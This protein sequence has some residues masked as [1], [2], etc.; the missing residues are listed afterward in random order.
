MNR[1]HLLDHGYIEEIEHW[2]SDE[3]IVE[4]ARVS[5]NKGFLGWGG[6]C[7]DSPHDEDCRCKG[8]GK[9]VGDEKLLR[10]MREHKHTS[11]F[12]F[13]GLVIEIQA[14]IF[15]F[16]EWQRHRT[17]S[18]SEMSARYTPLPDFNYVPTVERLM[19]NAGTSN[20]QAGTVT[21][22][23]ELTADLAEAARHGIKD[24][25]WQIEN[26]YQSLLRN[27]VPKELARIIIPVGRYSRMRAQ[28][29]LKNWLDFLTLRMDAAAQ[30]EIRQYANAV[31][32]IIKE[33]FPRTWELFAEGREINNREKA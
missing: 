4:T 14:P 30:W 28:A 5:T 18:Y 23:G 6:P 17:Q 24:L 12:E 15:V 31:G 21:G 1:V 11:P 7:P 33:R 13:A 22:S 29:V 10:Y 3:R 19:L 25:Y 2:G 27:G 32:D 8:S 16:R 20:K 9:L 26:Y